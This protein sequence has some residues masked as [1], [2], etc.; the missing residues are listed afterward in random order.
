VL[1][2]ARS[3]SWIAHRPGD[4][5]EQIMRDLDALLPAGPFTFQ[6]QANVSW[7]TRG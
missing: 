3:V 7:T 5:R 1:A 6:M 4:E 2:F